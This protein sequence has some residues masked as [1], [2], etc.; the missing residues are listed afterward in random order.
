MYSK[1]LKVILRYKFASLL[2][3]FLCIGGTILLFSI[4]QKEFIPVG[5]SGVIKGSL[6]A[7]I[8]TSS[9]DMKEYQKSIDEIL[10]KQPGIKYFITLTGE[11]QGADQ[12]QGSIFMFLK[13][14]SEREPIQKIT[15]ILRKEFKNK[16]VPI[17]VA[18]IAPM[19]FVSL[20]VINNTAAGADYSFLL[21][22]SD[23]DSVNESADEF[24]NKL[25]SMPQFNSVQNSVKSD[26]PKVK[27]HLLRDKMY[28]NHITAGSVLNAISYSF[29]Q[30]DTTMFTTAKD[31]Y[32]VYLEVDNKFRSA[33][34]DLNNIYIRSDKTNKLIPL[35]AIAEIKETVGERE[36][37][38]YN[39]QYAAI[40]S[41]NLSEGTSIGDATEIIDNFS[42][43]LLPHGVKGTLEG[44]AE[45]F[46]ESAASLKVLILVSVFLLYIVLGML[47]E[48]FIHPVTILTTL[49]LAAFG[50]LLS[51]VVCSSQLSLY[52]YIGIF[53][54]LGNIAKNGIILIDFAN[55]MFREKNMN[56]YDAIFNACITRFRPILMTSLT[57]IMAA[58][59]FVI[60]IGFDA[61]SRRPLGIVVVGG[62]LFGTAITLFV[63]PGIFLYMQKFQ[64]KFLDRFEF[65]RSRIKK[66]ESKK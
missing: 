8:G 54:L 34:D 59:P 33:I 56:S 32:D 2:I 66:V 48:S 3:W 24:Y 51:L 64:E 28:S 14:E 15:E 39:K 5:D 30:K 27:I 10:K 18:Y 19:P 46:A 40:I 7:P 47:Y 12:S 58:V 25:I 50:A 44:V 36:I 11:N 16:S 9:K 38:H 13:P 29:A 55:Q 60:G 20:P 6:V 63:T 49:P 4:V 61:D 43:E 26:M 35:S 62:Y 52:A 22:G 1:I 53:L 42:T 21:V 45:Q 41:F 65:S 57:T 17:G 37:S 31:Q 23:A